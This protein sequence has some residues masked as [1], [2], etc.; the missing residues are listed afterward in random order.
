MRRQVSAVWQTTPE[1]LVESG[2]PY[3][4]LTGLPCDQSL[5]ALLR[6]HY[7]EVQV[8]N[9]AQDW[10]EY[11][12]RMMYDMGDAWYLP[13]LGIERVRMPGPEIRIFRKRRH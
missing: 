5:T 2:E 10:A 9:P 6:T 4:V 8:F 1:E 11:G 12:G 7:D 3:I 13:N